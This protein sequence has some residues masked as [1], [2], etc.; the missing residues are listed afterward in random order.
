MYPAILMFIVMGVLT[1]YNDEIQVWVVLLTG[2]F[3]YL[4]RFLGFQAAPLILGFVLGPMM[5][6]HFRRTLLLSG[7]DFTAFVSSG[8]S[9]VC[10]GVSAALLLYGFVMTCRNRSQKSVQGSV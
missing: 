3:G 2:A 10:L 1:T 5:E 9:Q 6:E 8:I 4:L 7:G